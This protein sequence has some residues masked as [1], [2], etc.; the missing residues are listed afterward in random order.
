MR[1]GASLAEEGGSAMIAAMEDVLDVSGDPE[2]EIVT[3][4]ED[5]TIDA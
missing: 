4:I 3:N 1:A 2:P 5:R